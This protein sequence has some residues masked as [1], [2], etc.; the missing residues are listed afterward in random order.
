VI[1]QTL[2]LEMNY[3]TTLVT[4]LSIALLSVMIGAFGAH[5]LKAK[6]VADGVL[7]VFETA[8]RYQFF[9]AFALIASAILMKQNPV[10]KLGPASVCFLLGILCFS[11]SLYFYCLT[12]KSPG[13]VTPLGGVFFLAGWTM[14]IL[15][16]LK[17][18]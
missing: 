4:G 16:A 8:V 12:G 13:L 7:D 2:P 5:A 11:G 18:D 9:H 17:K 6:L 14:L 3:K 15:Q 10:W 1:I